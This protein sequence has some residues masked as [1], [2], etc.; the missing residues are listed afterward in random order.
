VILASVIGE[1]RFENVELV[2]DDQAISM[3]G[4][5][6][7]S[8]GFSSNDMTFLYLNTDPSPI[9][10]INTDNESREFINVKEKNGQDRKFISDNEKQIGIIVKYRPDPKNAPDWVWIICAG[11]GAVGTPAAAWHLA[12]NWRRYA[13]K[14][15]NKDFIVV[16]ETSTNLA[17]FQSTKE[18]FQR[19]R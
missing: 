5:S 18:V 1:H 15:G 2:G 4:N 12:S 17:A 8:F 13:N 10:S 9:F 6:F 19:R 7:I 3:S 14:Y 11:L 16:I